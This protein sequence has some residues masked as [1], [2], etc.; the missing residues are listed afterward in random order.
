ME[1]ILTFLIILWLG[2][3]LIRWS[4]KQNETPEPK[5]H[6]HRKNPKYI[7]AFKNRLAEL[8]LNHPEGFHL[9]TLAPS[10]YGYSP[11]HENEVLY[12]VKRVRHVDLDIEGTLFLTSEAVVFESEQLNHRSPWTAI[13]SIQ[14]LDDGYRIHMRMG[15]PDTFV[16]KEP[17][18]GFAVALAALH[19]RLVL[20]KQETYL[21]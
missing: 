19:C 7:E 1:L 13:A 3:K 5:D 4:M 6:V 11:I 21:H 18:V 17:S 15:K 16:V 20:P 9:P 8:V 12:G 2:P 10:Q 14:V